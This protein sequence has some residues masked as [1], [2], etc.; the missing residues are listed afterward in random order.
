[1]YYLKF[2][3]KLVN[4]EQLIYAVEREEFSFE[5]D[6]WGG[7][8]DEVL[9][10]MEE[11]HAEYF[12]NNIQKFDCEIYFPNENKLL[13]E[14]GGWI[15]IRTETGFEVHFARKAVRLRRWTELIERE[16]RSTK[17]N[18]KTKNLEN[19]S[20][21]L[22]D[23]T[24][25][26]MIRN[27]ISLQPYEVYIY[28]T[29]S[30]KAY[31]MPDEYELVDDIDQFA[32][33]YMNS[34]TGVRTKGLYTS[35][36]KDAVFYLQSRGIP[37]KVAEVMASLKQMYFTVNMEEALEEYNKQWKDAIIHNSPRMKYEIEMTE[38]IKSIAEASHE[39]KK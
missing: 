37:K 20:K 36:N 15:K 30:Q 21:F 4:A 13:P 10:G 8:L 16:L 33:A 28:K 39:L 7:Y 32:E 14:G 22:N 2:S 1:M 11:I 29:K 26:L 34:I 31:L 23:S 25:E 35:Q 18:L 9:D 17:R 12:D 3:E 27:R 6:I 5:E 38:T 24:P 19:A